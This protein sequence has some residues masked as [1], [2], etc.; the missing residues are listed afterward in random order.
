MQRDAFAEK[1]NTV[2]TVETYHWKIIT[3]DTIGAETE[4]RIRLSLHGDRGDMDFA[5]LL[6]EFTMRNRGEAGGAWFPSP[7]QE[8][9]PDAFARNTLTFGRFPSC[10]SIGNLISGGL[11]TDGSGW[12]SD[13]QVTSVRIMVS[14][15]VV[16]L[17]DNVGLVQGGVQKR[18]AF[19][20][21]SETESSPL[22]RRNKD[23]AETRLQLEDPGSWA[24]IARERNALIRSV[25]GIALPDPVPQTRKQNPSERRVNRPN[26]GQARA[27]GNP[28]LEAELDAY[29]KEG[30]TDAQILERAAKKG[31]PLASKEGHPIVSSIP[32]R[33]SDFEGF[34]FQSAPV[35]KLAD[36]DQTEEV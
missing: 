22:N 13:W 10:P 14:N 8:A 21:E 33:G 25:T 2:A 16:W 27:L 31:R 7:P 17:A 12:G 28:M 32:N 30:L 3:A 11:L 26:P 36:E 1:G 5:W 9:S 19:V 20:V 35:V 34:S 18:L 4:A 23:E 24:Q 15:S 29:R 6:P